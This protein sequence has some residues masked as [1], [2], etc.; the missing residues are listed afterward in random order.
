VRESGVW[1]TLR[2]RTVTHRSGPSGWPSPHVAVRTRPLHVSRARRAHLLLS[3]A[4]VDSTARCERHCRVNYPMIEGRGLQLWSIT[5]PPSGA[6]LAVHP[7][8]VFDRRPVDCRV[9]G[10]PIRHRSRATY[11]APAPVWKPGLSPQ[12][13]LAWEQCSYHARERTGTTEW[14]PPFRPMANGGVSWPM[15]DE[16]GASPLS[17]N[18]GDGS[19]DA[20]RGRA[21]WLSTRRG[22]Q[23]CGYSRTSSPQP[24]AQ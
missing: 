1:W 12:P 17:H 9:W 24:N 4:R 14:R 5:M 11:N 3:G 7:Y 2:S 8:L 19:D 16:R 10:S 20:S 23:I 13:S 6:L 15:N 21:R 18:N 22:T